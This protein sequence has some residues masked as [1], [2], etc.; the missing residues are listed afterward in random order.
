MLLASW[1]C[2]FWQPFQFQ[3]YVTYETFLNVYTLVNVF[4]ICNM[5]YNNVPLICF[6]MYHK[7]ISIKLFDC[8]RLRLGF[9]VWCINMVLILRTWSVEKSLLEIYWINV[10]TDIG[11]VLNMHF[12]ELKMRIWQTLQYTWL[13]TNE[14]FLNVYMLVIV[15]FI[16]NMIYI[17]V[18]LICF[19]SYHKTNFVQITWI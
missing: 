5:I 12:G 8:C 1:K 18:P 6:K 14:T 19:K 15:F 16:W 3:L 11:G 9:F 2:D 17:L 10:S 7:K 13:C 4:F